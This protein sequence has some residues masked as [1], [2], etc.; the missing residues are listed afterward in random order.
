MTRIIFAGGGTAGHIEP[1]ITVAQRWK[2]RHPDSVIT[3][4]GTKSGLEST[5]VPAAG[6]SLSYISKVVVPR[7]LSVNLLLLP[8]SLIRAI[9]QSIRII[10]KADLLIGFGGYVSAPAYL[11]AALTRTPYVIHEANARP[12]LANRLGALFAG[13]TA[14]A[15]PISR[16]SLNGAL[17]TGLPIKENVA[18]AYSRA[19]NDWANARQEAKRSLGFDESLPLILVFGGSQGSAAINTVIA[20]VDKSLTSSGVNILHSVG[21]RAELPSSHERYH[22]VQYITDMATAYLAADLIISRSGAVTC[23]EINTLGR[24]A[25]FIPLPI[26][27]GEQNLNASS[28]VSQGRAEVISQDTFTPDWLTHNV[29][30]LLTASSA[31]PI[32]GSKADIEATDKIVALLDHALSGGK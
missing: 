14:V 29:S 6:F 18:T 25:L 27:N 2:L 21:A 9:A 32:F 8:F 24:Y 16:G 26:G 13:Y 19:Q 5:L 22:A 10:S 30:R 7:R 3:F 31:A 4:L 15:H 28:L 12:G 11:A 20:R 1:A 23:A 17:L